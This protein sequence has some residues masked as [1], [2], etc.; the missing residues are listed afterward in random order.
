MTRKSPTGKGGGD[1]YLREGSILEGAR[2]FC[3]IF[4]WLEEFGFGGFW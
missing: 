3:G 1:Y 2:Y 4:F